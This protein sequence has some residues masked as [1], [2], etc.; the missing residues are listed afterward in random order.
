MNKL[1]SFS[2]IHTFLPPSLT[3]VQKITAAPFT[4]YFIKTYF[5]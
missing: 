4:E 2:I 3:D 1:D 5:R